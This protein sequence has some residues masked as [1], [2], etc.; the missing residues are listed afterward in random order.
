MERLNRR[1]FVMER[2]A[3]RLTWLLD[4]AARWLPPDRR[5]WAEAAR[6]EAEQVPAGRP[7]L[8]W[9]AGGLW[10]VLKEAKMAR[11]IGYWLGVGGV[12][13]I[14]AWAAWACLRSAPGSDLEA[15]T[16]RFRVLVTL[17]ALVGLPWLARR[18]GTFGPVGP[19]VLARFVRIAG[20]AA[21]CV[22]GL[23]LVHNDAQ[24]KGG[25]GNGRFN[26]VEEFCGLAVL[27]AAAIAP[28]VIRARWPQAGRE[29]YWCVEACAAVT[30][31]VLIPLQTI[32]V[33]TLALVLA[34]TSRRSPV[35]PTTLVAG[36]VG[37]LPNCLIIYGLFKL[38]PGPWPFL[39]LLF[40]GSLF[41]TVL[42]GAGA[43]W[44]VRDTG[45][46]EDLRSLR[47]RQGTYAGIT[48]GIVGGL[49][50]ALFIVLFFFMVLIGPLAGVLGG[51]IGAALAA[52]HR[53]K[54]LGSDRSIAVGLFISD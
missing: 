20:C 30:A 26:P 38:A 13:V 22:L 16:D 45:T 21:I 17:T 33:G 37:G 28:F 48:A 5:Q 43:A 47:V 54:R 40:L 35:R 19:G 44:L 15:L 27:A 50:P 4:R 51:R 12:A 34:A 2:L 25:L 23:L 46:G 53:P 14:A 29:A 10:L 32:A 39:W 41:C 1:E 9:I 42:A 31:L 6:A 7:R 18:Q 8:S 52:D 36:I 24:A 3:R 11:K 49:V